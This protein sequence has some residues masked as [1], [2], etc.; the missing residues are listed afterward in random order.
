MDFSFLI[1][2]LIQIIILGILIISLIR[3]FITTRYLPITSLV[4]FA[5]LFFI[6]YIIYIPISWLNEFEFG[7]AK[8][9][10][11]ITSY[12]TYISFPFLILFVEGIKGRPSS[13]LFIS[14]LSLD[15][16]IIGY[17]TGSRW[18]YVYEG[19]WNQLYMLDLFILSGILNFYM[20]LV[21]FFRLFQFVIEKSSGRPKKMPIIVIIGLLFAIMGGSLSIL[22]EIVHL[23]IINVLIGTMI[24]SFAYIKEPNSFFLSNT[25]IK[26][27]M[28]I[29]NKTKVPYLTMSLIEDDKLIIAASGI[30]GI[31]S[32]LQEI[33]DVKNPPL[34]LIHKDSGFLLEHNYEDKVS[35]ILILDKIDY[36]LRS[37]LKHALSLF[38]KKF[39]IELDGWKGDLEP[40]RMFK[41]NLQKIFK[42]AL[43]VLKE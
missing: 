19:F 38:I 7:S 12:L 5:G 25:N 16:F 8:F 26:A 13:P 39:K 1:L 18:Y 31:M 2:I 37:P 30:G 34:E 33:L 15:A 10:L 35:A 9:I 6:N 41:E 40:F 20:F 29:N 11:D 21:L 24:I 42:F 28:L 4:I 14:F 27:I 36:L 43:P 17:T 3:L 32:F 23:A 22:Y